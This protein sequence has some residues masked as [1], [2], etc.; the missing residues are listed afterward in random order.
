MA[1]TATVNI[2]KDVL[3]PVVRAQVAA[4]ITEA[5]GNPAVLIEKVVQHALGQK[6]DSRGNISKSNYD[7]RFDLVELM[8]TKGIHDVVRQ[9]LESWVDEQRPIIEDKVRKALSRKESTFAKALVDGLVKATKST[10]AFKCNITMPT[11]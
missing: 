7:N 4:G 1:D 6:V 8:A 2:P 9:T 3:E 10:W 5:L 11:D